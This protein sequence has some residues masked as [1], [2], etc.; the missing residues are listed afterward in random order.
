MIRLDHCGGHAT[1]QCVMFLCYKHY[2]QPC[3]LWN[4]PFIEPTQHI[5]LRLDMMTMDV[6][7]QVSC[8]RDW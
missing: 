1:W 6:N 4:S 5:F 7:R 3:A 8:G 2:T